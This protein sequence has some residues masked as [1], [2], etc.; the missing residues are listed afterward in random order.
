MGRVDDQVKVRGFRVELGE[1]EHALVRCP[2]VEA[3]VVV[4]RD[5]LVAY[6]VGRVEVETVRAWAR[7]V[8]PE[9]MVP[10]VFMRVESLPLTVNG[11][12]DRRALP[13]PD[14]TGV[15]GDYVAPRTAVEQRLCGLFAEVLGV[16]RVGIED[17]FFDLGGD[18]IMSIQLV[19]RARRAGI[20]ITP[21]QVFQHRTVQAL[22]RTAPH[23]LEAAGPEPEHRSEFSL[24]GLT[25]HEL[26]ELR[27]DPDIV[28]VW[29]LTPLQ[30]GLLFHAVY[31]EAGVDVYASQIVV[32]LEGRVDGGRLRLAVEGLLRR[33]ASLR[34]GFRW[35]GLSRPV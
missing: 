14:L 15:T 12:V 24:T 31:D 18:S 26:D 34:V 6:V 29:P 21:R 1:V 27:S 17:S 33:H 19:S 28:D 5:R 23:A 7:G 13:E 35:V 11:K 4:A 9:Y 32:R 30:E 22:A 25:Q 8:L 10:S 2:G 16:E 3:A 20:V